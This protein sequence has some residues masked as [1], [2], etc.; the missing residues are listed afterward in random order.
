MRMNCRSIKRPQQSVAVAK[1]MFNWYS[2]WKNEQFSCGQCGWRGKGEEA[3]PDEVG[4]MECPD[5]DHGVGYA[6][7]AS[8]RDTERAAALGTEDAIRD[9]PEKRAWVEQIEKRMNRF[10]REK[11][12]NPD[13]LPELEG[14]WLEFIWDFA[15]DVDDENYQIIRV[16][17][18]EVWREL[19]F[20]DNISR[21]NEIKALLKQ[22]YGTRFR[23]LTPTEESLEWLTGDRYFK[24]QTLSLT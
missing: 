8:L 7:F 16:G 19:A 10:E 24:L 15:E 14:Q 11:L 17:D 12:R 5:C 13:H 3:F 21:F 20:F 6:Q 1:P 23:S 9:L 4:M 2:N 22:K 18:V